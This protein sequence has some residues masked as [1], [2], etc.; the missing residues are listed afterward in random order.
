MN[1]NKN[2]FKVWKDKN[3]IHFQATGSI[4]KPLG[5]IF[6]ILL[7]IITYPFILLGR[8]FNDGKPKVNLDAY[9]GDTPTK[10]SHA[11]GVMISEAAEPGAKHTFQ[12]GNK[13][14]KTKFIISGK[15]PEESTAVEDDNG[16]F[17]GEIGASRFPGDSGIPM[18]SIEIWLFDIENYTQTVQGFIRFKE[19]LLGHHPPNWEIFVKG[20]EPRPDPLITKTLSLDVII[21]RIEY[22]DNDSTKE[23]IEVEFDLT[24]SVIKK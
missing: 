7:G 13:S 15:K 9:I 21:T 16:K 11:I 3:E 17:L 2:E 8:L 6:F 1:Q 4:G 10:P 23:P 12:G 19:S 22:P 5:A 20:Y 18:E 24:L 14:F